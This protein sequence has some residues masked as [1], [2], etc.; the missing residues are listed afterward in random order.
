[1][2]VTAVGTPT[3]VRSTTSPVT[4]TQGSGQTWA[5]GN[6]LLAFVT[7]AAS[8]S[9]TAISTPA[10][11]TKLPE[12]AEPGGT[13]II[14]IAYYW[15]VSNGAVSAPAFTST[16]TG[17]G[18]MTCT[19]MEL[20]G[21]NTTTP[22]QVSGSGTGTTTNAV[23]SPTTANVTTAG[24]YAVAAA[25][26]FVTT[27]GTV[28]ITY[29]ATSGTVPSNL[30]NDAT[31]SSTSHTGVGAV[32]GSCYGCSVQRVRELHVCWDSDRRI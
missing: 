31:T 18:V 17:T 26:Q 29:G 32:V 20:A 25:C 2:A 13:A 24:C 23:A 4:G 22:V 27:A 8:T 10:G 1:M 21:A 19:I 6:V 16:I 11:W 15:I 30:A 5:N 7:A 3:L 14:R 9:V 28:T 12:V